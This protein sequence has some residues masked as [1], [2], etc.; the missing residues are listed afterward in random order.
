MGRFNATGKIPCARY[1]GQ[2]MNQCRFGVVRNGRGNGVVTVFWPD[3]SN[4]VIFFENGA[5]AS[6]DQWEADGDVR[7]TVG[8]NVDLF[9]VTIGAQRFEIPEAVINGG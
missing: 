1:A 5:P 4:R 2:P 3:G 9:I 6:F 8:R 7:M